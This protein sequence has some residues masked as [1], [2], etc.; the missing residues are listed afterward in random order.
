MMR[1][2]PR[3][4]LEGA[5]EGAAGWPEERTLLGMLRA[6]TVGAHGEARARIGLPSSI[7]DRSSAALCVRRFQCFAS[8][9]DARLRQFGRRTGV[10]GDEAGMPAPR[11]A[12]P[13]LPTAAH[14]LGGLYALVVFAPE[15]G[16][17][18][19]EA[20]DTWDRVD[21]HGLERLGGVPLVAEGANRTL[22]AIGRWMD[23][24]HWRAAV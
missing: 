20:E 22:I 3:A 24:R 18:S 10:A 9:L 19:C 1:D 17:V 12:L 16:L 5:H 2:S 7:A 4:G 6:A 11:E 23:A 15:L 8:P 21:Q 13:H 14:L